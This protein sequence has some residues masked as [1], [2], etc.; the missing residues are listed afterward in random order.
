ML[1]FGDRRN[2]RLE[3][4]LMLN[5][6]IMLLASAIAYP[7]GTLRYRMVAAI[8]ESRPAALVTPP[9]GVPFG[10]TYF[11]PSTTRM[12]SMTFPAATGAAAA[13]EAAPFVRADYRSALRLAQDIVTHEG[14]RGFYGGFPINI[15]TSVFTAVTLTAIDLLRGR[16]LSSHGH[17]PH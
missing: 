16:L 3:S 1:V 11:T 15:A 4:R 2:V 13:A 10:A 12:A 9:L 5:T 17:H 7:F 6:S 14:I 8:G